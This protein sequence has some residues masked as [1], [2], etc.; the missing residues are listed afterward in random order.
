MN[1]PPTLLNMLLSR[2]TRR[3]EFIVG[4]AG[5]AAM[6]LQASAQRAMP[7][8]GFLNSESKKTIG[9]RLSGFLLGLKDGGIVDGQN[10]IIEYRWA[11]GDRDRLSA[12]VPELVHRRV[13]AIV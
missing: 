11:E 4:L 13:A 10:T 3:R 12:M 1:Q 9:I 7:V 5:T 6:P 8:I 2:H